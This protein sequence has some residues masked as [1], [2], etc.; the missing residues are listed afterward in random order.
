MKR[1]EKNGFTLVEIMI[2]IVVL[3]V[4]A[5]L[6]YGLVLS[7]S[8]A[9][10]YYTRTISELNT[11]GN[12]LSLYVTKY[13][14][15]PP[16]VSRDI[17]AGMKEFIQSQQGN[18]AWPDAPYPGSVY[19]YDNWPPDAYGPQ[20]TYQISVRMCNIGDDAGCKANAKKW[21]SD[22]VPAATLDNWDSSSAM[23]YCIKGSCRSHQSKPMNHPGFCVNCGGKSY[24]F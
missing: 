3:G 20:Q 1:R 24:I 19:D 8:R 21:L 16:D 12:A 14:D 13:N 10:T 23:Y 11:M 4:L 5:G 22:Y 2:V 17:P 6:V 18:A 7:R 9:R 15:Y